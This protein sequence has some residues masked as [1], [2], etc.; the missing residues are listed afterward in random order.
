[1]RLPKGVFAPYTGIQTNVLFFTKGRPTK[2]V[3]YYEHPYPPGCKSYSKTKPMRIE[4]FEVE[5]AWWS[6]RQESRQAWRVTLDQ[7][8][9]RNYNLDFKNP[10]APAETHEN[11]DELLARYAEAK[12]AA[13]AVREELKEALASALA[14]TAGVLA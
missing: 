10:N 13:D 14:E 5:K 8:R 9:E 7:I 11:P 4:E 12:A 3:W 1:M 2:E 6:D